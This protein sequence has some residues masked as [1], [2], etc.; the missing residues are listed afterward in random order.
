MSYLLIIILGLVIINNF[1]NYMWPEK[2][3]ERVYKRT[4][5]DVNWNKRSKKWEC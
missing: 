1:I 4:V 2:E 3:F 5:E